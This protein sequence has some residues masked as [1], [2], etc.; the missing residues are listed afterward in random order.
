MVSKLLLAVQETILRTRSESSTGALIEIYTDIRKGQCFNKTPG[1]YGAFPT[2]PYSHTPKGHGAR[3]PGMSGSVK[4]EIITRQV[5]LGLS[6]EN[7]QLGFDFLLLDRDEF[8]AAPS[9]YS[10]WSVDG[11]QQQIELK[12]GSLAYS[13]CQ[14]PVI[15]QESNLTRIEIHFTD[16]STRQIDGHILDIANSRHIFNRDGMVHHLRVELAA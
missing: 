16:G 13:I 14:V 2:D 6:I 11:R 8:L 12:A 15:L 10:Y 3:Q 4:E 7:G 9:V 5:E 1:V